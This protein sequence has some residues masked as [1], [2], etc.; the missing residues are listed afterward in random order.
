[1]SYNIRRPQSFAYLTLQHVL[2]ESTYGT[3]RT[4]HG[5]IYNVCITYS[6]LIP[7]NAELFSKYIPLCVPLSICYHESTPSHPAHLN[8][9][10]IQASHDFGSDRK[11]PLLPFSG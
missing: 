6:K 1:M 3:G 2:L 5:V 11:P 10:H 7:Y 8:M 4:L 9:P